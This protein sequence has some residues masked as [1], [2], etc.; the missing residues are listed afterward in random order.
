LREFYM[1]FDKR[2]T[3]ARPDLASVDF[4]GKIIAS[5]YVQ[6]IPHRIVA[7]FSNVHRAPDFKAPR[8]T[9]ALMGESVKV[10]EEKD[11]WAWV[12]LQNDHYV[13]YVPLTDIK[14]LSDS[15]KHRVSHIVCTQ[16]TF[17]YPEP[18]IKH[19]CAV[20]IPQGARLYVAHTSGDF[21]QLGTGEYV[22]KAHIKPLSSPEAL[23]SSLL[24]EAVSVAQTWRGVPY[25]WGGKSHMGCDCSGLVQSAFDQVGWQL[26]RDSDQQEAYPQSTSVDLLSETLQRG[27]LV[28]WKG[29]VG[30]MSDP[31]ELLHANGFHMQ[32]ASEPLEGARQ[33][34]LASGGG[35][36]TAIKR[37]SI[38]ATH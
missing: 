33:R 5:R 17:L 22:W 34:I 24:D 11:G 35:K 1:L 7:P 18:S 2:L 28:F 21:S 3:P 19:P 26:P 16:G 23:T 9:Q 37:L 32:V 14:P 27:D 36:I 12:Q 15:L 25:L 30:I 4:Q 6:G 38:S 31:H 20:L 8:E 13:G 10:F 29:H